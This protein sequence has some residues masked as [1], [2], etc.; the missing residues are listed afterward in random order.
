MAARSRS[1]GSSGRNDNLLHLR[2]VAP[3]GSGGLLRGAPALASVHIRRV[4]V[5]PVMWWGD[6]LERAVLFRRFVQELCESCNIHRSLPARKPLPDFLQQP[7]V[8]VGIAEGCIGR[9]GTALGIRTR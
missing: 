2:H 4:P 9:V 6:R 3:G 1:P 8:T 7:D 5:P